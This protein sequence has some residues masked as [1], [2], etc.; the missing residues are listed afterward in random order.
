MSDPVSIGVIIASALYSNEQQRKATSEAQRANKKREALATKRANV[1]TARERAKQIRKARAARATAL[2]QSQSGEGTGG[3]GLTGVQTSINNN[4]T[5]NMS[6][7]NKNI[8]ISKSLSDLNV[9]SGNRIARHQSNAATGA[10]I[11]SAAG[12]YQDVF[13]D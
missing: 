1:S 4:V 3:S 7:L 12:S 9:R 8:E 5:G 13:G 11:G 10:A 2:A 6:F